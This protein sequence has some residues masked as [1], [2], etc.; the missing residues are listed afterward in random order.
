[1]LVVTVSALPPPSLFHRTTV[2]VP[3]SSLETGEYFRGLSVHPLPVG[4]PQLRPM[5]YHHKMMC[6]CVICNTSKYFQEYL[7]AW[8]RKELKI[9][10]VKA[11]NS[12]GRGKDEI[13]QAY[14]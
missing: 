8:Q 2:L 7:N 13:T 11:Y 14:I 12:R 4:P 5:T 9:L 3:I 1:M 6:G 10:K